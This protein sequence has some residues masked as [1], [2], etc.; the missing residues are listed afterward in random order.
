MTFNGMKQRKILVVDDM[1]VSREMIGKLLKKAQYSIDFAENGEQALHILNNNYCYDLVLLDVEMPGISGFEVCQEMRKEE[2]LQELP[3]I[4]LT[5]YAKIENKVF[6]FGSGAQDYVTKPFS[7]RELLVRINTQI[8]LKQKA[9]IIKGMNNALLEKNKNI[10]D[11]ISYA[12]HIQKALSPPLEMFGRIVPNYFILNKP[13]DII[14]GD[15]FWYKQFGN[16][17]YLAVSDCT[18]HGVPGAFM[19]VLGISM[20]NEIVRFHS[21]YPPNLVLNEL[22]KKTI[23]S[24]NQGHEY[25]RSKDGMDIAICL[26]NFETFTLQYSGANIPL[27]L[28]RKNPSKGS[29]ELIKRSADRM[30]IGT[31]PNEN[32]SFTNHVIELMEGDRIVLFSDGYVSQFGG[33]NNKTFKI[34]RLRDELIELQTYPIQEQANVLEKI[35]DDW[36]G[37]NEQV[38]DILIFELEINEKKLKSRREELK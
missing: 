14:S 30:P 5:S 27:F 31:H 22:R 15:F 35:I 38:D 17:L 3:V 37:G 8:Q 36:R 21:L 16:L 12:L 11:S 10:T 7:P 33:E 23:Q 1:S 6:G 20:L 2:K 19:S 9:D 24:L 26:I 29:Y 18:G 34:N 28:M 25:M 32:K 4:F 13:K